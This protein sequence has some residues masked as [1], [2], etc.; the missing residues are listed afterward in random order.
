[1][2]IATDTLQ[3]TTVVSIY[4][5]GESLYELFDKVCV[6]S[7]DG[8]NGNG[9]RMVYFGDAKR[10]RAYFEDMG[11]QAMNRQT[12]PDFLVSVTD[13]NGRTTRPGYERRAPRNADEM[14][15]Y[16]QRSEIARD[17]H[18]EIEEYFEEHG[19]RRRHR[20]ADKRSSKRFS[21]LSALSTKKSGN[22]DVVVGDLD[23]G[24]D[25]KDERAMNNM[26]NKLETYK[27]SARAERAKRTRKGS[28]YT[29]SVPMQVRAVMDRRVK[30]LRGDWVAQ[31]IQLAS[32][33]FQGIIMGT[34]FLKVQDSTAAYFSRGGVLFL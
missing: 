33:I 11:Y 19:D 24:Y 13:P 10:A 21:T 1:L 23:P 9:G 29:I 8:T 22:G 3:L 4:Q 34:V 15:A 20:R 26:T 31:V 14:A 30:I 7:A 27:R 25:E 18:N 6:I 32:Y 17:V 28:P 2:R 16:F 5:A 12:T